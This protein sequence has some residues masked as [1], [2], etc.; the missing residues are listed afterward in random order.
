MYIGLVIVIGAYSTWMEF[1]ALYLLVVAWSLKLF[2]FS[3]SIKE[4]LV[5]SAY[6]VVA[7]ARKPEAIVTILF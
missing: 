7:V 4:I 2:P 1:A 5:L 3:I 6:Y